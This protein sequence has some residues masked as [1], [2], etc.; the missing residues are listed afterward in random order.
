MMFIRMLISQKHGALEKRE[1]DRLIGPLILRADL[2]STVG[3]PLPSKA[4]RTGV[5]S[6]FLLRHDAATTTHSSKTERIHG[7]PSKR[8]AERSLVFMK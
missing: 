4:R 8:G 5:M 6:P 3:K 7:L 2:T 1:N